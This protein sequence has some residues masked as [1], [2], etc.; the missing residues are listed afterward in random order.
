MKRTQQH[1]H[2]KGT[3]AFRFFFFV[4]AIKTTFNGIVNSQEQQNGKFKWDVL[5]KKNYCVPVFPGRH[6]LN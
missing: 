5:P 1:G 2:I 4:F 3:K 6:V